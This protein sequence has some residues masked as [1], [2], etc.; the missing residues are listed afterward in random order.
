VLR[1]VDLGRAVG[2]SAQ[3]ARRYEALGFLPP[4]VRTAA[5]QRRYG[6]RHLHAIRVLRALQ[7]GYG[8]WWPAGEVMRRLHAG[9]LGG[10]LALVD[11]RHAAL[12][13]RRQEAEATLRALQALAGGAR[14]AGPAGAAPG[15]YRGPRRPGR[16]APTHLRIGEAARR[17]GVRVSAV[18]YWEAR[19]LLHPRREPAS[20]YRLYD[21][22]QVLRL[23]VV[24][25]LREADHPFDA[26]RAVL[27]ELAGGRPEAVR[28]AIERRRAALI[29]ASE[30]CSL[31][32]AA[33]WG[34]AAAVFGRPPAP[35]GPTEPAPTP[36]PRTHLPEPDR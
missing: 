15:P 12:H 16:G 8:G 14:G 1:P 35:A 32:T 13:R 31:A 11:E 29:R 2:L 24:A 30:R 17:A 4:G 34:Y 25:A 21:G 7:A 23:R 10:A 36:L 28:L 18:R 6:P 5:N 33:F 19:G 27:D 20:R 22:E 9:D 3:Q 26:I